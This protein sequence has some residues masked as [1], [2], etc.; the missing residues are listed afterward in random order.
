[1]NVYCVKFFFILFNSEK[2]SVFLFFGFYH[3]CV[4]VEFGSKTNIFFLQKWAS[5]FLVFENEFLH[6]KQF[7]G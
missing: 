5:F 6:I 7:T 3:L 4:G 1:M 2:F